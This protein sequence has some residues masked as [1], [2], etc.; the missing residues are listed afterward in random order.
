VQLG[1]R[2]GLEGGKTY[3]AKMTPEERSETARKAAK[4]RWEKKRR[5]SE[6]LFCKG[7]GWRRACLLFF[8]RRTPLLTFRIEHE[9]FHRQQIP[10]QSHGAVFP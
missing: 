6:S 4:V 10:E 1:R 7:E 2:G 3:A 8:I 5:E 9:R